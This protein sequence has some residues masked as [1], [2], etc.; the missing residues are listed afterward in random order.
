MRRTSVSSLVKLHF[1][2]TYHSAPTTALT[3]ILDNNC[4]EHT[5][6]TA[7]TTNMTPSCTHHRPT[8][9][10]YEVRTLIS[11][12]L[13]TTMAIS[14][15]RRQ[16]RPTLL[17]NSSLMQMKG[18]YL[19]HCPLAPAPFTLTQKQERT[20]TAAMAPYQQQRQLPRMQH[21]NLTQTCWEGSIWSKHSIL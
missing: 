9:Q 20:D 15:I 14:I 8:Q 17:G 16:R 21:S 19:N 6:H 13:K 10:R 7:T 4:Q 1:T 12:T 2:P 5:L 11:R 18:K 3:C